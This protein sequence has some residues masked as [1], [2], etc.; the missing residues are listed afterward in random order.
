MG[1]GCNKRRQTAGTP[2]PSMTAASTAAWKL[3]GPDGRVSFYG[4]KLEAEAARAAAGGG[5]VSRS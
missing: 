2:S 5:T 1:C 4:S 3:T